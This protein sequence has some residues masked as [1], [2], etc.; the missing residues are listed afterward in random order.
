MDSFSLWLESD[1]WSSVSHHDGQDVK[2]IVTTELYDR[3]H[4]GNKKLMENMRIE[5]ANYLKN[6]ANS[7]STHGFKQ[8]III[9]SNYNIDDGLHR[10]IVALD[11]K[12][13][14]VPIKFK[15]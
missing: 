2:M 11:Q 13:E 5:D 3:Q 6:L 9:H 15:T 10:L 14:K 7:I 1:T 4:P 8:P 12:I